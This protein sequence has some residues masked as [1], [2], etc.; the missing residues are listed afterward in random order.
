MLFGIRFWSIP[1]DRAPGS[2]TRPTPPGLTSALQ[3]RAIVL[4]DGD[5]SRTPGLT[6]STCAPGTG[7]Q[8][9]TKPKRPRRESPRNTERSVTFHPFNG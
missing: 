6:W 4:Q 9:I 3:R 7:K 8:I 5:R 1:T 2:P